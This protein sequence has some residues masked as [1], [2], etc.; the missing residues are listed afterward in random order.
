VLPIVTLDGREIGN[1]KPGTRFAQMYA[2]YQE[3]K[4]TVMRATA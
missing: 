3:F 4:A 2:W 1:G